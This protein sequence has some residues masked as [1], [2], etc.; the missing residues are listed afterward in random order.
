M[1][2]TDQLRDIHL[3]DAVN[4]WPPA[5]G[6]WILLL[7][8]IALLFLLVQFFKYIKHR[9][10]KTPVNLRA[11]FR[12]ELALIKQEYKGH[13]DHRVLAQQVSEFLRRII[14]NENPTLASIAAGQTGD[15][16]LQTLDKHFNTGDLFITSAHMITEAPYNPNLYFNADE[17]LELITD[18]LTKDKTLEVN[19]V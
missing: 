2:A 7:L 1:N 18:V 5:I 17:L 19:H 12:N 10:Q 15:A 8:L 16:W 3:P 6:W 4:W 9:R 13:G 14:I 11:M